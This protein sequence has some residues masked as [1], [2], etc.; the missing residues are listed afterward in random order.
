M[1]RRADWLKIAALAMLG[2]AGPGVALAE[3]GFAPSHDWCA[4]HSH[5]CVDV[6][7]LRSVAALQDKDAPMTVAMAVRALSFLLPPGTRMTSDRLMAL[8]NWSGAGPDTVI[9]PGM[10]FQVL[11]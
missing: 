9:P 4:R 3:G 6:E 5:K 2:A 8:N 10:Q 11:N 1:G 7:T